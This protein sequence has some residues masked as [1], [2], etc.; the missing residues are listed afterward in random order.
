MEKYPYDEC[1]ASGAGHY[2]KEEEIPSEFTTGESGGTPTVVVQ[3]AY[4]G[5]VVEILSED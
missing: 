4:C 5:V 2:Y 1:P 3:C